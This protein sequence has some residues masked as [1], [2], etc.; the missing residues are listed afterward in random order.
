LFTSYGRKLTE[1]K[2]FAKC[3]LS[4]HLMKTEQMRY[5]RRKEFD[6]FQVHFDDV[7]SAFFF[8]FIADI[9]IKLI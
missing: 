3:L 2:R 9:T 8:V 5:R 4:V 7:L 6:C 1:I